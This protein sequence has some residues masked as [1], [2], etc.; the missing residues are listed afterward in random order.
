MG[1]TVA[2]MGFNPNN[3]DQNNKEFK[4]RGIVAAVGKT[5]IIVSGNADYEDYKG[6]ERSVS[7]LLYILGPCKM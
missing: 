6:V 3:G 1:D 2:L 7:E 4:W 5:R